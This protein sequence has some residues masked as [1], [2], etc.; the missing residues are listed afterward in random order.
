MV[1]LFKVHCELG[2][3][4]MKLRLLDHLCEDLEK[5]RSIQLL[6]TASYEQFNAVLKSVY[7]RTSIKR[8]TRTREKTSE[9][10]Q[11]VNW[12]KMKWGH[13][14]RT[15]QSV[16]KPRRLQTLEEAGYFITRDGL[17]INLDKL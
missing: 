4:T 14:T 12:L 11:I 9:L 8:V 1:R 13:G 7:C 6:D 15:N 5:F 17:Q 10:K 3:F 2:L 16:V